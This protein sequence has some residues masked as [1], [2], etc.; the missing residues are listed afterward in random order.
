MARKQKALSQDELAAKMQTDQ[1]QSS[2]YESGRGNP[3]AENIILMA[4]TLNVSTD[5]LLGLT[6]DPSIAPPLS[7]SDLTIR[8]REATSAW[9]RGEVKEAI[10][11]ILGQ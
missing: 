11:I 7:E 10:K 2:I 6:D 4:K 8:E 5:W 3:T 9:R 1:K